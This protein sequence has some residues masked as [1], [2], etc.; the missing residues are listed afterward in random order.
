MHYDV[1]QCIHL[2]CLLLS[3]WS[4]SATLQNCVSVGIFSPTPL[5]S[6]RYFRWVHG[7][8]CMENSDITSNFSLPP[9]IHS[10][11]I[12]AHFITLWA[13]TIFRFWMRLLQLRIQCY[14]P[15]GEHQKIK[16]KTLQR[17]FCKNC[18]WDRTRQMKSTLIIGCLSGYEWAERGLTVDATDLL[19]ALYE[20]ISWTFS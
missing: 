15:E 6:L 3:Q 11:G 5:L 19:L 9:Q 18:N 4:S 13:D 17:I 14:A 20:L 7:T 12:S 1:D 10:N 16:K 2:S 8:G